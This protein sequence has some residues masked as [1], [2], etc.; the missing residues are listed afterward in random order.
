[1]SLDPYFSS[2]SKV[3][4]ERDWVFEIEDLGYAGWEIV[5]DGNYRLE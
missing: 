2:S 5:A 4:A 3:W 1:M